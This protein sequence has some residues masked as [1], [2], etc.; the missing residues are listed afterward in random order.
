M[1]RK[2]NKKNRQMEIEEDDWDKSGSDSGEMIS[3]KDLKRN[4]KE[5]KKNKKKGKAAAMD[6]PVDEEQPSPPPQSNKKNKKKKGKRAQHDDLDGS[7]DEQ[8]KPVK[9]LSKKEKKRLK[10]MAKY[11]QQSEDEED[12]NSDKDDT[13]PPSKTK[14]K[15]GKK[16]KKGNSRDF[17]SDRDSDDHQ[18]HKG[19]KGKKGK[20]KGKGKG[21]NKGGKQKKESRG[22]KLL[23]LKE[24]KQQALLDLGNDLMGS[25]EIK[26]AEHFDDEMKELWE[27]QLIEYVAFYE[28]DYEDKVEDQALFDEKMEEVREGWNDVFA[29]I[30]EE[31]DAAQQE[32][33]EK[34]KERE[35]QEKIEELRAQ[36]LM[37]GAVGSRPKNTKQS[38]KKAQKAKLKEMKERL[39]AIDAQKKKEEE[40]AERAAAKQREEEEK[41]RKL[42]EEAEAKRREEA[43]AKAAAARSG[44]S[45][46]GDSDSEPPPPPKKSAKGKGKNN[47]RGR[48]NGGRKG[49]AGSLSDSSDDDWEETPKENTKPKGKGKGKAVQKKSPKKKVDDFESSE[50]EQPQQQQKKRGRGGGKK[51]GNKGNNKG[52][53]KGKG[54]GNGQNGQKKESGNSKGPES[55]DNSQKDRPRTSAAE[56]SA[57]P[58]SVDVDEDEEEEEKRG[59]GKRK[60]GRGK[61]K[62]Q[63]GDKAKK[64]GKKVPLRSPICVVMGH[65]DTGKTKILDHIRSSSVQDKEAGGITQQ[66]GATYL[67]VEYI[68]ERTARLSEQVS[69]LKYKIPGLL[70]ID[71]PG[72]ESFSNL[73]SR[74]SSMCDIAVLVV[75][76]MHGLE[77]QTIESLKMLQSRRSPFIVALN[78][79]DRCFGWKPDENA[80]FLSTFKKQ[81]K[82]TVKDFEKRL[83]QIIVEFAGQEVNA[84]IYTKNKHLDR[85]ISLVPTSA[86]TG[87]GIPDL[88]YLIVSLTKKYMEKKIK[89]DAAKTKCSVLEVKQTQGYG[90]TI[91]VIVSNGTLEK[92]DE[93]VVCGMNGPIVTP[94]RALLLPH[95]AQEMRVK[96]EYR[97]VKEV[98]ASVGVRIAAVEDLST[99]VAGAPLFIV[100]RNLK[101]QKNAQR[102]RDKIEELSDEVQRSFADL[103]TKVDRT[104]R[105]VFVQASTLGSLEALITFLNEQKI[106]ISGIAIGTIAKKH[107]MR[108]AIMLEHQR[109]FAVILAFNVRC[110][111]EARKMAES[112]GVRLFEAEIIYHLQDM[113]EAYIKKLKEDRKAAAKDV[114][115]FPVEFMIISEEHVYNNKNPLVLGVEIRRGALRMNTPVCAKRWNAQKIGTPLYL[116]R[117]DGIKK[118]DKDVAMAK[119]G[120]KVSVRILGD[121][122]QKNLQVGRSF[123]VTDPLISEISRDSIDALKAN[124]ED[125]MKEDGDTVQHLGELKRYFNV[126]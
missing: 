93:I 96:G 121:D 31:Y 84:Q 65:V 83:S 20:N 122:Q 113:F 38:A 37:I 54:K 58:K 22:D 109:E 34:Q 17:D 82:A 42:E 15:K 45:D 87:E 116:G 29:L 90:A 95:E 32:D 119:M 126:I 103:F 79:I 60:K 35:R 102:R 13:P 125:E 61:G 99:A 105:G 112:M 66:I 91:D 6:D 63:K 100:P 30:E 75:D 50:D 118:D 40:E 49:K 41:K 115:V 80:P 85:D 70:F 11:E 23:R 89:F 43:A 107:V 52:N 73:R 110:D 16:S 77:P 106:P 9:K 71:T 7:D 76:L 67:S 94:I 47:R 120:D 19:G 114:A 81:D 57:S 55:P 86:I 33:E 98:A 68:K 12:W 44:W 28:D 10:Q 21:K 72:H 69:K 92:S 97:T 27:A 14:G 51:G 46:S 108:A 24:E 18:S 64:G 78:K 88:L 53:N 62:Q 26:Y 1:P 56:M 25:M 36:G 117:V 5:K 4:K 59:K 123:L 39:R 2:K 48:G 124:F 3:S 104:G 111:P 8:S 74:G 101:G